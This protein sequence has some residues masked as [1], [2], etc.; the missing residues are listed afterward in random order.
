MSL[1]QKMAEELKAV[2]LTTLYFAIWFGALVTLKRLILADYQI[3]FRG[4]SLALMGALVVAKVVL[5]LEHV[6]LGQWLRSHPAVF[7]VIV[8]TLVYTVGV[9]IALLLEKA[10]EARHEYGGFGQAL[11]HVFEHRD[12][13]HVWANTI[14]VGFALLVF[15]ALSILRRHIGREQL[16]GL[17]LAP[18]PQEV[19]K[20][21]ESRPAH[22]QQDGRQEA[23]AK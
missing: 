8:R 5:I 6:S 22:G 16:I 1:K 9:F 19:P 20:D 15:N 18:P 12:M 3:A 21:R 10:F 23:S 13:P 7:D 14:C 2:V 4:W 17:F 11:L